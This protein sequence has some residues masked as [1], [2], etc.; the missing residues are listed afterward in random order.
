M[1]LAA[2]V[3]RW[4]EH[5][6]VVLPEFLSH[7]DLARGVDTLPA[8]FPTA[9]DFHDNIDNDRNERFRDEFAGIDNFPFASEEL[10]LLS[11]HPKVIA[12]ARSLLGIDDIRVY[13]IEAWAKY[14]GAANYEQ[15][16]HRDYLNHSLLVPTDDE[17]FKPV[18]M[19][20][21]LSDV[22]DEL[23]PPGVVSTTQT[24]NMPALPNWYPKTDGQADPDNLHW[25]ATAGAPELYQSETTAAGPA[26]TIVAYTTSTFHRGRQLTK[27]RGARYTI[28]VNFRPADAD[29]AG[30]RSWI[31]ASLTD[32][33]Q[34]FVS[35][36]SAD[37]LSLFGIPRPG[38]P[39]WTEQTLTGVGQRYP[40]LDLQPW[41]S[42][43]SHK[44][45]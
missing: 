7:A 35:R 31:E 3:E 2:A 10:S 36:A 20:I 16:L 13:S 26:G 43:L 17:R 14:T 32:N 37:Q 24:M 8:M 25:V 21:Y 1:D 9:A 29:W 45:P 41:R 22:P 40:G 38:H 4:N 39:Y 19:F 34:R 6:F 15:A 33:W 12:L 27:P 5:G 42:A 30:R 23:G 28:H 11:V 44:V 18:E